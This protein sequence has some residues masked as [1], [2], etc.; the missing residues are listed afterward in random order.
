[1]GVTFAK[2]QRYMKGK[3]PMKY[4]QEDMWPEIEDLF[5]KL[6]IDQQKGVDLFLAFCAMDTDAG[7]TVDLDECFAYLGG[8]RTKYTERIWF[9]E[10]HINEEGEYEEGLS[11]REFAIVCW[12]YC[13]MSAAQMARSIFEIFD[14][15]GADELERA[16]VEAMYRL[17]YD[18]EEH[19]EYYVNKLPFNRTSECI[20]REEFCEYVSKNKHV[21]QP[22][23]D[24]QKRLRSKMGGYLMWENLA[25]FRR[26][27]FLVYDTQSKSTTE[28][29]LNIVNAEDPNRKARKQAMARVLAEKKA[30]ADA[31]DN[32]AAE[33]LRAIER[34]REEEI[35]RKELSA[36]DRFMKLY[37]MALDQKRAEFEDAEFLVDDA[38]LRREKRLELFDLLDSYEKASDEYWESKDTKDFETMSGTE[39]DH[40]ARFKDIMKTPDG[41]VTMEY[42][43]MR[44]FF[45]MKDAYFQKEIAVLV[46]KGRNP[47]IKAHLA[48]QDASLEL[49]KKI[50][51]VQNNRVLIA[52]GALKSK[53]KAAQL[54]VVDFV[55]EGKLMKSMA[56]KAE[57]AAAAELAQVDIYEETK[58]TTLSKSRTFVDERKKSRAMDLKRVD[59]EIATTYGS[60]ITQWEYCWDRPNEKY[61]YMN[62]DTMEVIHAKT[63]ICEQCDAL[64]EQSEK[65]CKG[66][67][68]GRS[69]KNQLLYRPLGFKDIRI[70]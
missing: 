6:H 70:D 37:W 35:R 56:S 19:D 8:V 22:A 69:T 18:C 26:R 65:R 68:A 66:C 25:G 45:E 30:L 20:G 17:M 52:A 31:K 33:E 42:T 64:F 15:E 27:M 61:V 5:L 48:I 11:F 29:L 10:G 39:E 24:Y 44:R 50:E 1:M 51:R 57:V 46:A 41:K 23:M 2:Q 60:R 55:E 16:D 43:T 59:F 21:I 4:W 38:W 14:V 9:K 47:K 32:A 34:S 53:A 58:A 49:E 3:V 28:A 63:A 67:D 7:G 13:T 12:N 36:E 40:R 62:V 54:R